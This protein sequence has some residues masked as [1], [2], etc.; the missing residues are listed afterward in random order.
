MQQQFQQGKIAMADFW[1]SRVGALEDENESRVVG[2]IATAAAPRALPGGSPA[3][4]FSW[5]GFAIAKNIIDVEAEAAF[6]AA[7]E[8]AAG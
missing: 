4:Q 6:R 5:D 1:A 8:G 7:V 3:V 2:K